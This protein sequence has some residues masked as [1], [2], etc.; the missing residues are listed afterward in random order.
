MHFVSECTIWTYCCS[1]DYCSVETK[2][3]FLTSL[4]CSTLL[5]LSRP[6]FIAKG[7]AKGG[8][9]AHLNEYIDRFRQEVNRVKDPDTDDIP[10]KW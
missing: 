9:T 1:V 7:K 4:P 10:V 8:M 5:K 2:I 6:P 3:Y